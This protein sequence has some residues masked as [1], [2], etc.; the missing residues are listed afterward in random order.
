MHTVESEK[1]SA[2]PMAHNDSHSQEGALLSLDMM[3][4][5]QETLNGIAASLDLQKV[6]R[7]ITRNARR[8][9]GSDMAQ[10]NL[11]DRETGRVWVGARDDG[12]R[13]R[14]DTPWVL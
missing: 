10:V 1:E 14:Q 4:T 9:V 8:L 2:S 11:Y 3:R 13:P 6:L 5:V 12:R 7:A